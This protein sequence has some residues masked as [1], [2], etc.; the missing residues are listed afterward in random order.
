MKFGHLKYGDDPLVTLQYNEKRPRALIPDALR[1]LRDASQHLARRIA[2]GEA[3][4]REAI[5]LGE[6]LRIDCELAEPAQMAAAGS[7]FAISTDVVPDFD[8]WGLIEAIAWE[9][10]A[11]GGRALIDEG[12][13]IIRVLG[14]PPPAPLDPVSRKLRILE[15]RCSP[16]QSQFAPMDVVSA[17]EALER[18]VAQ[19]PIAPTQEMVDGADT[20]GKLED[21]LTREPEWDII[22]LVAHAQRSPDGGEQCAGDIILEG[23]ERLEHFCPFARLAPL[24]TKHRN[25]KTR[26][27]VLA[28]CNS[29]PLALRLAEHMPEA[30]F[31]CT[32]HEMKQASWARF[33]ERLYASL[34]I[35]RGDKDQT[36]HIEDAFWRALEALRDSGEEHL[37]I[38]YTPAADTG[39][40]DVRAVSPVQKALSLARQGRL[41]SA[42]DLVD[43]Q[44]RRSDHEAGR[45]AQH[46]Q[47]ELFKVKILIENVDDLRAALDGSVTRGAAADWE[48]LVKQWGE[49]D[50]RVA[51]TAGAVAAPDPAIN[52]TR[53]VHLND[54]YRRLL[55][56]GKLGRQTVLRLKAGFRDKVRGALI[57][58]CVAL[59]AFAEALGT[60]PRDPA[61]P[62]V[63]RLRM[64]ASALL[65][66]VI[67]ARLANAEALCDRSTVT[68]DRAQLVEAVLV[69]IDEACSLIDDPQVAHL[70]LHGPDAPRAALIADIQKVVVCLRAAGDVPTRLRER[71]QRAALCRW[72]VQ[73]SWGELP[74]GAEA[75]LA[76]L[77]A[78][79]GLAAKVARRKTVPVE[80][81]S[82]LLNEEAP[83][84]LGYD[85]LADQHPYLQLAS[86]GVS[87]A[88]SIERLQDVVRYDVTADAGSERSD[89]LVAALAE[90]TEE[91]RRLCLD[92]LALPCCRADQVTQGL[93]ALARH[94]LDETRPPDE[95]WDGFDALDRIA[96]RACFGEFAAAAAEAKA[97]AMA[98]PGH[99]ER[100]LAAF[101]TAIHHANLIA[102]GHRADRSDAYEKAFT[103]AMAFYGL[104]V[105]SESLL[106]QW[107]FQRLTDYGI[108]VPTSLDHHRAAVVSA[109]RSLL[110]R[111]LAR[112]G[113][114]TRDRSGHGG[115]GRDS[116]GASLRDAELVRRLGAELRAEEAAV[117]IARRSELRLDPGTGRIRF[118]GGLH[119]ARL[120]GVLDQLGRTLAGTLAQFGRMDEVR[121]FDY[122]RMIGMTARDC[123]TMGLLVSD[124]RIATVEP[125]ARCLELLHELELLPDWDDLDLEL[126]GDLPPGVDAL[127]GAADFAGRY[128]LHARL[129]AELAGRALAV[130]AV[131]IACAAHERNAARDLA[132]EPPSRSSV[133]SAL[134]AIR[135]LRTYAESLSEGLPRT[136]PT[137]KGE[138]EGI[139]LSWGNDFLARYRSVKGEGAEPDDAIQARL[140]GA[141][142]LADHLAVQFG[143]DGENARMMRA[144]LHHDCAGH[145]ATKVADLETALRH[146]RDAHRLA[147]GEAH[148]MVDLC[149]AAQMRAEQLRVWTVDERVHA[150]GIRLLEDTLARARAFMAARA[151]PH[152]IISREIEDMIEMIRGWNNVG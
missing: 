97:V 36:A 105:G 54:L 66:D 134:S 44:I 99:R 77:E 129:E 75:S 32:A 53:V 61:W 94:A 137:A 93:E 49:R 64:A 71:G 27:V 79:L 25:Q 38:L 113:D 133:V 143:L 101:L 110:D 14:R 139:Y 9:A 45:F 117:E 20:F 138:I 96:L 89:D 120:M 68:Q 21:I 74:V 80:Q 13:P 46:A 78:R 18:G 100:L 76:D 3:F 23:K 58:G 146:L 2:R 85:L 104:C 144:A 103:D 22:H 107:I 24:L 121:A 114:H 131:N 16:I 84:F 63:D 41:Q 57:D 65:E 125:G 151:S 40:L 92:I 149:R 51:P 42:F 116:A 67:R 86:Y 35:A 87:P 7:P 141:C 11:C 28:A 102:L 33:V 43:G 106:D 62:R 109:L 90:L 111:S 81:V 122:G 148:I 91:I 39:W 82:V 60:V 12:R 73:A 34:F 55:D 37:P 1:R 115:D 119:A 95:F 128:P 152:D 10:L 130:H 48:S 124:L 136:T 17:T 31:V 83:V 147:P 70:W 98:S 145:A 26:L 29:S 132:H 126:H 59:H 112:F 88:T 69:E 118:I 30:A 4:K 52:D 47:V 150:K 135:Q 123:V 72:L 19:M 142:R 50:L 15:V 140:N 108:A 56:V 6:R 127:V 5:E 8:T